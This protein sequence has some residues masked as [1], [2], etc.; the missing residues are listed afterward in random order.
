MILTADTGILPSIYIVDVSQ[1][2][3]SCTVITHG[4]TQ[5][6]LYSLLHAD[7]LSKESKE[8]ANYCMYSEKCVT[9]CPCN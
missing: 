9:L 1:A 8:N 2:P 6:T 4:H 7:G 5:A 3:K